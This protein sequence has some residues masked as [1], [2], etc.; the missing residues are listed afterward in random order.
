MNEVSYILLRGMSLNCSA[1][2]LCL[3]ANLLSTLY[4]H[5]VFMLYYDPV[6]ALNHL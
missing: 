2:L 1:S 5:L 6:E 4:S 3:S